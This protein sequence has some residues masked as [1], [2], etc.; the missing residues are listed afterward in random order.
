MFT[1]L[2]EKVSLGKPS[3]HGNLTLTPILLK[4]GPLSS[5]EPLSLEEALKAG[6]LEVS[7][8]SSQGSVPELRVKSLSD[9]P[10]LILDGEELVGA[11]QN[12]TVNVT[13]LVP[14][15]GEVVIPVSC[16]EAGRWRYSRPAFASAE[17]VSSHELR[18]RKA[19]SVTRSLKAGG[20]YFSDQGEVWRSVD[21]ALDAVGAQS[22]TRSMSAGYDSHADTIS[23][24][25]E[26]FTPAAG[27]VG[28]IYRIGGVLVGLDLFGSERTFAR[29]F[30]KLV[31]G[32]A[33]QALA[34]YEMSGQSA[35]E[36]SGFLRASLGAPAE[37]FAAVGMGESLRIDSAGIGGAALY[38]DPGIV[39]L[40]TFA[41]E[42]AEAESAA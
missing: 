11:K 16:I 30:P 40:F 32:S 4:D 42:S 37:K 35:H 15:R 26:A 31:R 33:L 12:R 10:V 6:T 2:L 41:Q 22:D 20:R 36:E 14:P 25:V 18:Y 24:Y 19:A 17:R 29:A 38:L 13:I 27:Q 9:V 1:T 28:V 23:D 8:V 39:H 5:L 21:K 7:E 34:G 3:T